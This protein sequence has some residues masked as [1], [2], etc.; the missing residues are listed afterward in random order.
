MIDAAGP[1]Q[2]GLPLLGDVA[3]GGRYQEALAGVDGGQGDLGGEDGAVAAAA[4]QVHA[5]AHQPG[6]GVR[7]VPGAQDGWAAL[8]ASGT[9]IS[10]GCAGQFLA[11]IPEQPLGLRVD[12]HDPPAGVH[13]HRRVRR[14]LQQPGKDGISELSQSS[15]LS[16]LY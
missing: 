7:R 8:M 12:Q 16:A 10:T 2:C 15:S 4:G 1:G 14:R 11:R 5:R 6:L 9:R 3:D 13:A